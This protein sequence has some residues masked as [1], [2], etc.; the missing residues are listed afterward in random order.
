M[1]KNPKKIKNFPGIN[2]T[3]KNILNADLDPYKLE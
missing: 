3:G 1:K 2:F